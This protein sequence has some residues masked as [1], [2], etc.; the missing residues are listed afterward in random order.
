MSAVCDVAEFSRRTK[1]RWSATTLVK[2]RGD[3]EWEVSGCR[4]EELSANVALKFIPD[5]MIQDRAMFDQLKLRPNAASTDSSA[6]VSE[7]RLPCRRALRCISVEYIDGKPYRTCE[8]KKTKSF[9]D[10]IATWTS[11]CDA[12]DYAHITR[13]SPS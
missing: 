10:A 7:S 6:I 9:A 8:L 5:L 11:L 1:S 4:D 12:L 13:R 2:V 3:A